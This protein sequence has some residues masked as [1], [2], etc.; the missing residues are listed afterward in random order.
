MYSFQVIFNCPSE[1]FFIYYTYSY[2]TNIYRKILIAFIIYTIGNKDIKRK[3]WLQMATLVAG[4]SD[5]LQNKYSLG[6]TITNQH[7]ALT[8]K[9]RGEINF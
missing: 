3:M 5:N 8:R 6:L 7:N 9:C 4:D 1:E 2:I